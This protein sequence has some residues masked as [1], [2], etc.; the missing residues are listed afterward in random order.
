MIYVLNLILYQVNSNCNI[1]PLQLSI[2]FCNLKL[3]T[4]VHG[5][6]IL[7]RAYASFTY[8]SVLSSPNQLYPLT[9]V[10]HTCGTLI[11]IALRPL[12][13]QHGTVEQSKIILIL[14]LQLCD[15][16]I[17]SVSTCNR[18][19]DPHN[20]CEEKIYIVFLQFTAATCMLIMNY[21]RCTLFEAKIIQVLLFQGL[22]F[23]WFHCNHEYI[24]T[25]YNCNIDATLVG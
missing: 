10:I 24:L 13:V 16:A 14:A 18:V 4:Q 11:Q 12:Q 19:V 23:L 17:N 8:N 22:I 21:H 20:G 7:S 5:A 6:I 15:L 2:I 25:Q 1:M 9:L 3:V